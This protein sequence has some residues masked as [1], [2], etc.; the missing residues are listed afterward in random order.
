[1]NKA[2]LKAKLIPRIEKETEMPNIK[3][4]IKRDASS[5]AAHEKNNA[6]KSRVRTAC[7]K[8]T[9]AVEAG[10]VEEAAKLLAEAISILDKAAQSGLLKKNT[11]DRKKA[12]LQKAVAS[13]K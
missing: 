13:V 8:V 7:K 9:A 10:N 5:K 11:V 2:S 1:M 3:S 6:D 12:A 4:Q